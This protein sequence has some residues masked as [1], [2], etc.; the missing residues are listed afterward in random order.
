MPAW[1]TFKI[2]S[3]G[4]PVIRNSTSAAVVHAPENASLIVTVAVFDAP[5]V[6][7]EAGVDVTSIAFWIE[8]M[9]LATSETKVR[10]S[11]VSV[12]VTGADASRRSRRTFESTTFRLRPCGNVNVTRPSSTSISAAGTGVAYSSSEMV[13]SASGAEYCAVTFPPPCLAFC[14]SQKQSDACRQL[15]GAAFPGVYPVGEGFIRRCRPSWA[16]TA[17]AEHRNRA[18]AMISV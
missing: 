15:G 7:I 14:P 16:W 4:T 3:S 13:P 6:R 5:L 2:A 8:E 9:T 10:E 1:L 12:T 17:T 18:A 11:P